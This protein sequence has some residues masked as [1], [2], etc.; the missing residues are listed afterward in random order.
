MSLT[1]KAIVVTG[2]SRGLGLGLVRDLLRLGARVA[3]CSRT[4][5]DDLRAL[6]A[7]HPDLL[8]RACAVGDE[9]QEAAFMAD[10]EAW[11]GQAQLWGLVNNAGIAGEGILATFPNVDSEHILQVNLMGALRL[12]RLAL[13]TMLRNPA[14]GR[15][16][17]I[18]SIVGMRGYTGLAAYSASKAG[19]DGFTRALSR[20]VG[21][22]GITVNSVAPG[23][24]A[25][26]ISA[27]L[28]ENQREQIRRRT[29][30]GRLG[31]VEDV[32]PVIRFLLGEESRFVTGHTLVVDG[33]LSN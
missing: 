19:M 3:C 16:I 25:T 15:I 27:G 8:W 9:A 1:G 5:S 20:E 21:R 22:R 7:A 29:P 23:Y 31:E 32:V 18:S 14:G 30:M 13:R 28:S 26:E 12:S 10:V 6:Q 17:N 11:L 33:G 24:L 4:E 2:A